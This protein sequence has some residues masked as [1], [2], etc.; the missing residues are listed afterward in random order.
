M[1]TGVIGLC[2][3]NKDGEYFGL[4]IFG[5]SV[6]WSFICKHCD[7]ILDDQECENGYFNFAATINSVKSFL[8]AT[9][10]QNILDSGLLKDTKSDLRED[11]P[12]ANPKEL[13]EP[14]VYTVRM[15]TRF[16]RFSG[17]FKIC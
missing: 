8:I 6:L 5:W 17:G 10:L 14:G 3:E 15:F 11:D 2:P 1:G 16:A 12:F 13:I 9:R 7:D 4:N